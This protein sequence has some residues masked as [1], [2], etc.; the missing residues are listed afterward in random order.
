MN[1]RD[2]PCM[3]YTA[4]H[5]VWAK[6]TTFVRSFMEVE[7]NLLSSDQN[8]LVTYFSMVNNNRRGSMKQMD[9]LCDVSVC[10][11]EVAWQQPQLPVTEHVSPVACPRAYT[12]TNT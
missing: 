5:F 4:Q 2:H 11:R 7:C 1:F 8:T 10:V 6:I 3:D 9:N 12:L